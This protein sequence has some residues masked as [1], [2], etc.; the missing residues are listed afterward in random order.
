MKGFFLV[1]NITLSINL[2]F[3][4]APHSPNDV[5]IAR[6]QS[7]QQLSSSNHK[8]LTFQYPD[9]IFQNL[10]TKIFSSKPKQWHSD[11][12]IKTIKSNDLVIGL[13]YPPDKMT[14]Q[15][16][17]ISSLA[18]LHC[19]KNIITI[20]HPISPFSAWNR[21]TQ[22][23]NNQSI[24]M[25]LLDGFLEHDQTYYLKKLHQKYPTCGALFSAFPKL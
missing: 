15:N 24:P 11:F 23:C 6:L 9:F 10:L 18:L 1:L 16:Y 17:Q 4:C 20:D 8:Q 22:R 7:V 21:R 13:A 19:D 12:S 5:F 3:A 14:P 25:K 2:A